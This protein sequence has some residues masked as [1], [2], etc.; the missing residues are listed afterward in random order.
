MPSDQT[1]VIVGASHAAAQLVA[2][3]RQRGWSG[4]IRLIGDEGRVPY[5]RPP[6][7]KA[8]L[9]GEVDAEELA[10]RP[11]SFYANH[12]VDI[13][14]DRVIAIDRDAKAVTLAAG[15][16]TAYDKLALCTG[17]RVIRLS[18]PGAQLPGVRYLRNLADVEAIKNDLA[19]VKRAVVIG[20]GYI[21]LETAASLRKLGKAVVVLEMADRLLQ[22]VTAPEVSA[23]YHRLHTEQGVGIVTS[24]A[25]ASIEGQGRVERVVCSDG[26]AF[27]ADMVIVGVGITP[28]T[29]LAQAAGLSVDNGI[30]V[31]EFCQ[32]ADPDIVAAG[33]C[34]S[35][36]DPQTGQHRRLESV[37][38]AVEQAKSA[39]AALCG[40]P[41]AQTSLPWFWSDQY[42]LKLQMAGLNRGHD[43]VVIRG[44]SDSGDSFAAFY[45]RSG[46]MIAADCINR[47]QE[48]M[49]AK[50]LLG[51]GQSV[52]PGTVGD[53]SL[54]VKELLATAN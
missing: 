43:Q 22:R 41:V 33:D 10:I 35:Q 54:T 52:D 5:E 48:F 2:S 42:Y 7:S 32:T 15:K 45:F 40:E 13:I 39:A 12:G 36:R 31:D 24:A 30:V 1:C 4:P 8:Y 27:P 38:F 23:F 51:K 46:R 29:E 9:A 14:T 18:L 17:A 50:R 49:L 28:A 3:L 44:Q 6:L 37:P 25:A 16:V 26:S 21:G 47:P 11:E 34:A 53:E 20:G 19:S